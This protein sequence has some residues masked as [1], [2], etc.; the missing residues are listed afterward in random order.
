MKNL[1]LIRGVD[2]II[3]KYYRLTLRCYP[4]L[5]SFVSSFRPRHRLN[6]GFFCA[7]GGDAAFPRAGATMLGVLFFEY[8]EKWHGRIL[9]KSEK[10]KVED[11]P[12]RE[13]GKI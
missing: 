3:N 1:F 9:Y 12:K 4:S 13:T 6:R 10:R 2:K 11:K 7:L 8:M 5:A